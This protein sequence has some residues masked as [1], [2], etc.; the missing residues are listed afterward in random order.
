MQS[1]RIYVNVSYAQKDEAKT[2]GAKWEPQYKKWYF[3]NKRNIDEKITEYMGYEIYRIPKSKETVEVK[4]VE[5][6]RKVEEVKKVESVKK[7]NKA[8]ND[9]IYNNSCV[10]QF[11]ATNKLSNDNIKSIK[12]DGFIF[13]PEPC[14]GC[15]SYNA[16]SYSCF[17][18]F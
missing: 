5:E 4:K 3:I 14:N 15:K 11:C 13:N 7:V 12:L 18:R 6:V 2:K 16:M 1:S 9:K 10:C 17:E 8:Q